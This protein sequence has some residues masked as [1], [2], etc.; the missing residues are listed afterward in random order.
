MSRRLDAIGLK[1]AI[2]RELSASGPVARSFITKEDLRARFSQDLE[3]DREEILVE[4]KLY[5]T[6][7]IIE[8]DVDLL[9]LFASVFSDIVLGF[10][11]TEANELFLVGDKTDFSEQDELTVAHEFVHGLQQQH[12]DIRAVGD[13][14]EDNADQSRAF[15]ALV[16]GD[17]TVGELI[18]RGTHFDEQQQAA[19][20]AAG[21]DADFSA[22]RAAPTVIQRTIAFPYVEGTSFVFSLFLQTEDFEVID[23]AYEYVPRSTEQIIHPEKY[24]SREEPAAV[25]LPDISSSLGDGWSE[26]D[27]DTFGEMFLRSYLESGIERENAAVAA[28]GWG[29]D[30]FALYEGPNGAL[31]LGAMTTWDAEGDAVEFFDAFRQLVQA[32]AAS[33][34]EALEDAESAFILRGDRQTTL[35]SLRG[36]DVAILLAP[37]GPLLPAA[38]N[39]LLP[40]DSPG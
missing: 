27:R 32:G 5:T 10:Y 20:Q 33:D 3:E 22:F 16:E 15:R 34:W 31:A 2:L 28:T 38:L 40:T 8:P 26:I 30:R 4:Q 35:I 7:G 19:A 25:T 9:E 23:E 1:T 21:Q 13:S 6:L 29:G 18:Y 17:A 11:D 24:E 14:I 37:E 39:R 12:F 36:L